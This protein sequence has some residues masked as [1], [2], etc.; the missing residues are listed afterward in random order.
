MDFG[1][2]VLLTHTIA[3]IGRLAHED[4]AVLKFIRQILKC[5][6]AGASNPSVS[7]S[8]V[9]GSLFW[10]HQHIETLRGWYLQDLQ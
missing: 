7:A 3:S 1:D 10:L 9:L 2:S 4:L 5:L 6:N 8:F